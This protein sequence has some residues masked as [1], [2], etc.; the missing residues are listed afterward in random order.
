LVG[1]Y[2]TVA[3]A[4]IDYAEIGCDLLSIRGWDVYNDM[5]DYGRYVLPL[6]R[7]E[8]A[9]REATGTAPVLNPDSKPEPAAV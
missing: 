3:A 1:S 8:L 2:E 9:H 7:Q 5:V 4:L 6:A